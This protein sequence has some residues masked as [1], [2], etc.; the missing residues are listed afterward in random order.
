[1]V[2]LTGFACVSAGAEHEPRDLRNG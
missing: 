1:M 2:V